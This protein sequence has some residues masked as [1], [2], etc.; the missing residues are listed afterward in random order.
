M[1]CLFLCMF[2][3]LSLA[4]LLASSFKY[5]KSIKM[6]CNDREKKFQRAFWLVYCRNALVK[7][8]RERLFLNIFLIFDFLFFSLTL[9]FLFCDLY[10]LCVV[11]CWLWWLFL[12]YLSVHLNFLSCFDYTLLFFKKKN[13]EP[14]R[15]CKNLVFRNFL[16]LRFIS[17]KL[18]KIFSGC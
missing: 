18:R 15:T 14:R 1:L 4:N 5:F 16:Q 2:V 3:L 17:K 10:V 11:F 8:K 9:N 13:V 12:C 7:L 6:L